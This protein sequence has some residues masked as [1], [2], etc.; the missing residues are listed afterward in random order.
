MDWARRDALV[1][2]MTLVPSLVSR[3]RCFDLFEDR[4]VR[5]AKARSAVLRGIVR[6]IA[7][8]TGRVASLSLQ[9]A[10][11]DVSSDTCFLRCDSF[12]APTLRS[13]SSRA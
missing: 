11:T 12:V 3:N 13:P 10:Q 7:G 8:M 5:R 9:T 6:H 1:V 4:D 2:G